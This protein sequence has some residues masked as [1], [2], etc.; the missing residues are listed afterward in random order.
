MTAGRQQLEMIPIPEFCS[1]VTFVGPENKSLYI[2]CQD[3]VY[4]L[5]V[6]VHGAM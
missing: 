4:S 6:R 5:V 2:T 3:K 1:N